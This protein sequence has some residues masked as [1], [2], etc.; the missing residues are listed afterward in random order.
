[1]VAHKKGNMKYI[2]TQKMVIYPFTKPI[3]REICIGMLGHLDYIDI[4]VLMYNIFPTRFM[5]VYIIN[6]DVIYS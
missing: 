1:M 5:N 4:V 6:I 3:S 2:S